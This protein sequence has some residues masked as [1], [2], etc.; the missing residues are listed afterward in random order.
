MDEKGV[1]RYV[2]HKH[3][4]SRLTNGDGG[5]KTQTLKSLFTLNTDESAFED[6]VPGVTF[7]L[8]S[9]KCYLLVNIWLE[10]NR[11]LLSNDSMTSFWQ[12]GSVLF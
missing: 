5:G 11:V 4:W 10:F 12:I 9:W 8:I 6:A 1:G 7:N 2:H 3:S